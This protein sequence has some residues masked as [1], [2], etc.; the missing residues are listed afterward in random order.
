MINDREAPNNTLFSLGIAGNSAGHLQQTGESQAFTQ[1]DDA[2][3]P[4]A[5]FP[6]YV[7]QAQEHY[8]AVM[9]YSSH[10]LILPEDEQAKAQMEPEVALKLQATYSADGQLI[11]LTPVAMTLVNDVTYRNASVTRLAQKKNWG[12]ASKGLAAAE[13][14]INDFSHAANLGSYRLCGF[15]QRDGLWQLAGEDVALT[16]YSY[17]YS[18][19][20]QWLVEQIQQQQETGLFHNI[21]SLL[22]Q[23]NLPDTLLVAIGATRYSDYGQQHQLL[24]GDQTVVALYDSARYHFDEIEQQVMQQ[25][26]LTALC[27]E[28]LIFLQQQVI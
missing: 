24:S 1:F 28:Q 10:Q 7:P 15:H 17:F 27:N 16:Q 13:I 19:L 26:D 3:K 20:L 23:A 2:N 25:Q 5:L 22:T 9:P 6:I 11:R 12:R 8:L 14:Q 18:E 4:Q 21:Q